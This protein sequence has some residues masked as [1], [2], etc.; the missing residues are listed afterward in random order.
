MSEVCYIYN[1]SCAASWY[2]YISAMLCVLY[3]LISHGLM[4]SITAW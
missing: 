1:A 4:A 2:L 3:E